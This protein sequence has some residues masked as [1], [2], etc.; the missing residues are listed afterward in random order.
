MSSKKLEKKD[1][2]VPGC[3]RLFQAVPAGVERFET[4][5]FRALRGAVPVFRRFF[6]Y[7]YI[8]CY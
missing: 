7:C 4:R 2:F 3:S 6:V 5:L 8:F 1:G